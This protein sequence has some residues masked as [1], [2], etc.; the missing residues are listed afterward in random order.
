MSATINTFPSLN[1]FNSR[2]WTL[3]FIILLHLGF[4]WLLGS[5]F[6][7]QII[8]VVMPPAQLV[9]VTEVEPEPKREPRIVDPAIVQP[10][11][12]VPPTPLPIPIPPEEET[13]TDTI[14]VPAQPT[15]RVAVEGPPQPVETAPEIDPRA[16]LSEP[17]YPPQEIRLGHQGTV[18]LSVYVLENGRV[19]EVRLDQSSGY[20]K[21]DIAATREARRWR[22]K[23][24]L[25]DGVPVAM[26]KQIPITFQLRDT[27]NSRILRY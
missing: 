7:Q 18:L 26:W 17:V 22:L 25:R 14:V 3:L 23:P 6:S 16:G 27:S 5:G 20:A 11:Q 24:G 4:F 21:L 8:R 10:F 2:S 9:P 15:D 12:I 13:V 19:G 1:S